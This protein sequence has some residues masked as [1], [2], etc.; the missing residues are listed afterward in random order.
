MM[1]LLLTVAFIA[2]AAPVFAQDEAQPVAIDIQK[3]DIAP[4]EPFPQGYRSLLFTPD[5]HAR[6]VGATG[7]RVPAPTAAATTPTPATDT[8]LP[9]AEEG[10]THYRVLHLSGIVYANPQDWSIWLNGQQVT[11]T[12]QPDEV[13][14]LRVH[15]DYIEL[16][17]Y[18]AINKAVVPV[19]LRPQQHFSLDTHGFISNSGD[20]VPVPPPVAPEQSTS[21]TPAAPSPVADPIIPEDDEDEDWDD[22]EEDEAL[23]WDL[24]ESDL[25]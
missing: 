25:P 10:K 4:V 2:L 13:R 24:L 1:R 12:S 15:R 14:G 23:L 6:V 11:P 22:W 3:P 20:A 5:E 18:D 17:W 16:Q 8:P 9:E 19:R 7:G 21:E